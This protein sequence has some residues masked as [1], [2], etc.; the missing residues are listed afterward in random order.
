MPS[1]ISSSTAKRILICSRGLSVHVEDTVQMGIRRFALSQPDWKIGYLYASE[2]DATH[3]RD[4]LAWKPDGILVVNPPSRVPKLFELDDIP[5]VVTNLHHESLSVASS[6]EPD[7]RAVGRRAADYFLRN[8]FEHFGLLLW[9][10]NP[11]F[12]RLREEGFARRLWDEKREIHRF[13]VRH[14]TTQPWYRNTEMETWL[15][16]LPKPAGV[17]CVNDITAMRL[18]ELCD[19]QN[20]RIPSEISVLGTDNHKLICESVRPN[21]SSIPQPLDQIG[22]RAAQLLDEHIDARRAGEPLSQVAETLEPGEVVERQSTHLRAL[23]DPAIAKAASYLHDH[24]LLDAS[25]AEAAREAG[26]NR[27]ALERGFKKHLNT[28]PGGYVREVKLQHAKQLLAQT[29]LR[30]S[31]I[32][33]T[34][35]LTQEH[36]ANFFK[37]STGQTPSAYRR[38]KRSGR[39]E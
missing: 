38:Q 16:E 11:P 5:T 23:P 28:T 8:R 39:T 1:T 2:V 29:D 19:Q 31:E 26:L 20:I 21:I 34:C 3:V 24:A 6:V 22:F 4:M 9:P 18:L 13:E 35:K 27:R 37:T 33:E 15:K 30:M 25:I 17:Y 10:G 32:A 12:S 14:I 36:F 7:N